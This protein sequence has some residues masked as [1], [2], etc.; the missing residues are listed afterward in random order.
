MSNISRDSSTPLAAKVVIAA[1]NHVVTIALHCFTAGPLH[2][3]M[4]DDMDGSP[5]QCALSEISSVRL[6]SYG[7]FFKLAPDQFTPPSAQ[8][9]VGGLS[10]PHASPA[11]INMICP[12]EEPIISFLWVQSHPKVLPTPATLRE[13]GPSRTA[14]APGWSAGPD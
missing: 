8:L 5:A 12:E 10:H 3:D 11:R 14:L 13:C 1:F 4:E 7:L 9:G 2:P 6:H